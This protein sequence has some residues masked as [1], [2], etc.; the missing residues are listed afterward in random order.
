MNIIAHRGYSDL[1]PENTLASFDLAVKKGFNIF[2]LDI[3]LTKDK[4]PIVF[5]DYN[6]NRICGLNFKINQIE[7]NS[8]RGFDVGKWKGNEFKNEI[9]P[10]FEKIL[11]KY[12]D[13]V[14]LQIELKSHEKELAKLVIDLLVKTKWYKLTGEPYKVPGYSIT[15][16]DFNNLI[17]VR[18]ISNNLRTGWLLNYE[19][20]NFDEILKLLQLYKINML[21]PNVDDEI[22]DD[23]HFID[24]L[25]NSGY[26]LCAWGAKSTSDVIKMNNLGIS[27]MTVNWPTK[28]KMVI[29]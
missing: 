17:E 8:L 16:F 13:K 27:G 12:K 6:L 20:H 22:W 28:A 14:H 29:E 15:S 3:Q 7:F 9:I 23:N 11:I 21:I 18:K 5:H 26:T 4:V 1:A 2:E 19:K 10:S 24:K 25:R